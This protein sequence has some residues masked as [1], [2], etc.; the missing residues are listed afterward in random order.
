M[1]QI[2]VP[3]LYNDGNRIDHKNHNYFINN[4]MQLVTFNVQK[5]YT[6]CKC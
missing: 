1:L 4:G 6:Y 2:L 3:I 5:F